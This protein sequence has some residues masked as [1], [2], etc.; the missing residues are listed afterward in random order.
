MEDTV[1]TCTCHPR[2]YGKGYLDPNCARHTPTPP[3]VDTAD[4][5][6]APQPAAGVNATSEAMDG[7]D[8]LTGPSRTSAGSGTTEG[9]T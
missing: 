7:H 9:A 3:G 1:L 5:Q 2:Y 6:P 4:G 8:G